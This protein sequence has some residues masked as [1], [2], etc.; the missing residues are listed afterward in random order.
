MLYYL[1]RPVAYNS[2]TTVIERSPLLL[3]ILAHSIQFNF[4][5]IQMK[6]QSVNYLFLTIL[7]CKTKNYIYIREII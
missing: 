1:D 7:R 5:S 4:S 3:Q 2:F 6:A